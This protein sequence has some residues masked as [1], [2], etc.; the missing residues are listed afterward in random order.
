M[1][2]VTK[3]MLRRRLQLA[4]SAPVVCVD[5]VGVRVGVAWATFGV[6]VGRCVGAGIRVRVGRA[7][8][9]VRVGRPTAGVRVGRRVLVGEGVRCWLTIGVRVGRG[10]I[11]VRVGR[12]WVGVRVGGTRVEVAVG[13]ALVRVAVA[14]GRVAVA[15]GSRR[16]VRVGRDV[17]VARTVRV[18]VGGFCPTGVLLGRMA[19]VFVGG[20]GSWGSPTTRRLQLTMPVDSMCPSSN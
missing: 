20:S 11:G 9:G 3:S 2:M 5:S 4:A 14:T 12:R 6:R 7:G 10:W 8:M 18:G 1:V 13:R 17:L 15:V 19:G 16:G